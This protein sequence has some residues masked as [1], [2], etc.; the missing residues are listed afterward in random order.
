MNPRK[1]PSAWPERLQLDYEVSARVGSLP[2]RASGQ[3]Q[4]LLQGD[5]YEA[6]LTMRLP[7]VGARIQRSRGRLLPNG[8]QPLAFSDQT[9]RLRRFELD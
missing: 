8:V 5:L 7:L 2:L 6:S 9:R 1:G 4:W 3:L